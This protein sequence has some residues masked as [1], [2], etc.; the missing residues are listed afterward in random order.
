MTETTNERKQNRQKQNYTEPK[1]S[2]SK[3]EKSG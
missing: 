2:N 3:S 1:N